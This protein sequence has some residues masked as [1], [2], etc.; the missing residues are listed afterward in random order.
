MTGV[1]FHTDL[2]LIDLARNGLHYFG[3]TRTGATS[4]SWNNSTS[5][6]TVSPQPPRGGGWTSAQ[7]ALR[8]IDLSKPGWPACDS[9][10]T[11]AISYDRLR[12]S[13]SIRLLSN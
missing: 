11:L 10:P 12:G 8:E 9:V 7:K 3:A 4:L 1:W 5:L 2:Q 6:L 13:A